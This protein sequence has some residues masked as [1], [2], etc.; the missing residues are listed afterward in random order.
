MERGYFPTSQTDGEY[1]IHP[2]RPED[3]SLFIELG[4]LSHSNKLHLF[5]YKSSLDGFVKKLTK[6][7]GKSL[8][9][10]EESLGLFPPA[11]SQTFLKANPNFPAILLADHGETFVNN[12]YNSIFDNATNLLFEYHH[13]TQEIPSDSIQRF[14]TDISTLLAKSIY[15]EVTGNA[16]VGFEEASVRMVNELLNCYILDANC[17]V[18]KA[19]QKKVE[20]E[21]FLL[22]FFN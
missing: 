6:N 4:Q 5:R 2:I 12:F 20:I 17:D 15:E 10:V 7:N 11:S 22:V 1:P 14:I 13:D 3:I 18:H 19:I 16:Y 8:P 21:M 9:L